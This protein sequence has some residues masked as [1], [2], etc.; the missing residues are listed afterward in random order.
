MVDNELIGIFIQESKEHLEA[1]EPEILA[2][3]SASH[4]SEGVNTIFRGVHSI[5]GSSGFFGFEQISKLSHVMEN[6][7][8]LVRDGQ[9]SPNSEMVSVLLASTDKLKLMI[10]DP[11]HCAEVAIEDEVKQ[12]NTF[13]PAAKGGTKPA[14]DKG[15]PAPKQVKLPDSLKRFRLDPYILK[16]AMQHGHLVFVIRLFMNKDVKEKGRTPYD[17]FKEIESLGEFVD[18]YF[19][20]SSIS[21][22]DDALST[23]LVC[24]F[25]FTTVMGSPDM[26]TSVFDIP[27]AQVEEIEAGV[28]KEWLGTNPGVQTPEGR[29]AEVFLEVVEDDSGPASDAGHE[30]DKAEDED[31]LASTDHL[32]VKASSAPAARMKVKRADETIRVNVSLLDSLMNLAG[33]MVLSRNQL[34]RI[35]ENHGQE[36]AGLQSI[37]QNINLVTSDMHEKVMQTRLQALGIIFGKFTRIIRDLAMKLGKEI[38]LDIEGEDVELDKSIV[39]ALSDPLTHLIRNCADHGIETPEERERMGKPREGRVRLTAKHVGGQVLIEII[40]DGRGMNPEKLRQKAIEKGVLKPEEAAKMSDR[41]ALTIIFLPGFSTAEKVSDV[42]GRGVGMDVVR[43]NIEGLGGFVDIDSEVG[44]GTRISLRLP[45]TLAIIPA[46]IVGSCGRRFAVPQVN[47][48]EVVRLGGKNKPEIIRGSRVLRLRDSLLTLINLADV[49]E[50]TP[51]EGERGGA[52]DWEDGYVLVLN[53]DNNQYGLIVSELLDSEE[54]AVKPLSVYLKQVGCYSGVTIMGDGKVAMI[55]DIQGIATMARLKFAENEINEQSAL[56][57]ANQLRSS[58]SE[59][60]LLFRNEGLE[61]FAI[62]LSTVARIERI[63]ASDI[64][65]IGKGEYLKLG[66]RSLRLVRMHDHMP[67]AKPEQTPEDLYVLVPKLL[68]KPIGI[69]ATQIVDTVQTVVDLDRETISGV[70]ILGSTFINDALVLLVDI[71]SLFESVDPEVFRPVAYPEHFKNLRVLL[72][73]NNVFFR[74]VEGDF[75]RRLFGEVVG[76][77]NAAQAWEKLSEENFHVVISDVEL[78]GTS[79]FDLCAKVRHSERYKHLPF[80][81]LSAR[82]DPNHEVLAKE[83]LMDAYQMKFDKVKLLRLIESIFD[84]KTPRLTQS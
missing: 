76:V 37:I 71:Y 65:H 43:T 32:A 45:L 56:D 1:I 64:E 38:I 26:I 80:I 36:I 10:D 16:N 82:Q 77:R 8:A 39:E 59:S 31:H 25:L 79:G 67:I 61:L 20:F 23:D 5:K 11:Q 13:L 63:K 60:L 57:L 27:A 44:V 21:G 29:E 47:L 68:T 54:I 18:A 22:L 30:P 7:M 41:Q 72:V 40:D 48:E 55:V 84:R 34:I 49:L 83:T 12:L 70:G 9:L 15:E 78:P 73:D 53:L 2:M 24:S 3:E 42:S 14:Q 74:T 50:L 52:S 75:L 4:D 69:V 35:A 81:G 33:E 51:Q 17:Y 6:L 19:D 66:G 46:M 62:N 28:I 58:D